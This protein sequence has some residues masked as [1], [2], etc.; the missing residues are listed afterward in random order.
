MQENS[1][2]LFTNWDKHENS[3]NINNNFN[4]HDM[5]YHLWEDLMS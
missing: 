5:C 2:V 3:N 4:N 1:M